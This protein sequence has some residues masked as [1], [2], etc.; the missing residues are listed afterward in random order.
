MTRATAAL[1]CLGVA[2]TGAMT[3]ALVYY[4]RTAA[5]AATP[6]RAAFFIGLLALGVVLYLGAVRLIL[7]APPS[8]SAMWI[9]LGVAVLVRLAF[10]PAPPLLSTDIYR[11]VW[12]GRV[13]AAGINPYLYV[14]AD[15]ALARLRDAEIY[16]KINRAE[17]AR[18]IYP[19][20]AEAV[21]AA[22]GQATATVTGM[23]AVM[24]AFEG[25]AIL[26]LL[27]VLRLAGLPR[28]RI[29]IYAWNPLP[30][31]AFAC[32]GHVDAIA[33]GFVGLALLAR[34]RRRDGWAGALLALAT[35]S[36]F[37]PVVIAPAFVRG[38]RFW[39]PALAGAAA[40]ALLYGLYA[41]AGA[42]VLGFLPTY[43]SE[44]GYD[45]GTGF[46]LLAGLSRI[47]ALPTHATA[48][49][50][51]V[52]G[53]AS[54]VLAI[55]IARGS[56]ER[57]PDAVVLCR[58]TAVLAGFV[59]AAFSPHYPWYYAWLA[60]PCVVSPVP[61]VVWL[62]AAPVL[63]Y[64]DPFA[65]PFAWPALIFVPAIGLAAWSALQR[66][67]PSHRPVAATA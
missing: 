37:L 58:D 8:A 13:Q 57:R 65:A 67:L 14:P 9:V 10:L 55:W 33:V 66:R 11:Y 26:S 46:W 56:S 24:L 5:D 21:F 47:V 7:R 50:V 42:H 32:D 18:T 15:P 23:K 45:T 22:V 43:G 19:P 12:D 4:A 17:Y 54:I 25:V 48:G 34:T 1:L 41:S 20:M 38:G 29:L 61:A 2:L 52:V 28:E 40:I 31:W 6:A 63:L 64:V 36:K 30:L 44:E 16:P 3:T 49:Y 60:L 51:A 27:Q 35:L 53:A 39:R 59:T 62:S